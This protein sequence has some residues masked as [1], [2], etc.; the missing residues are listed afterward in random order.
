MIRE[1][2]QVGAS[3]ATRA[4]TQAELD[5]GDSHLFAR[6]VKAGVLVGTS[7]GRYYL[8]AEG[9]A[10]L[11]HRRQITVLVAVGIVVMIVLIVAV[12]ASS[13]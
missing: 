6:L 3:D 11:R 4:R 8:S 9:L 1:F 12:V 5:I 13:R 7:E 2:Q 10:R